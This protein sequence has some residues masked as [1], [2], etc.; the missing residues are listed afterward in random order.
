MASGNCQEK[1]R[2]GGDRRCTRSS[3]GGGV[4]SNREN[5][6]HGCDGC[7]NEAVRAGSM[8]KKGRLSAVDYNDYIK[9]SQ[10]PKRKA[11]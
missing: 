8:E 3:R 6:R 11:L 7:T 5:V 1:E 9:M 4:H 2:R 10:I